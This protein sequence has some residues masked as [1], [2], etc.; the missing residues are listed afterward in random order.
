MVQTAKMV[1]QSRG[2]SRRSEATQ[3]PPKAFERHIRDYV[4]EYLENV[5]QALTESAEIEKARFPQLVGGWRSRYVKAAY[6]NHCAVIDDVEVRESK[7]G[8]IFQSQP[9]S[10]A[11]SYSAE[12]TVYRQQVM[13]EWRHS[14]GQSFIEGLFVLAINARADVMYGYCTARDENDAMVFETWVLV[15]KAGRTE[16]EIADLLLWGENALRERTLSVPL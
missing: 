10:N 6:V 16:S 12:G 15:K 2:F 7:A 11:I 13:G 1:S 9:N 5:A 4:P 3:L 8:I 14:E